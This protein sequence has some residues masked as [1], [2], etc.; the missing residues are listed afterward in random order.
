MVSGEW[1]ME[2]IE[3]GLEWKIKLEI[4]GAVYRAHTYFY[5]SGGG[6]LMDEIFIIMNKNL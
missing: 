2:W 6:G 3:I 1:F 5:A 4:I